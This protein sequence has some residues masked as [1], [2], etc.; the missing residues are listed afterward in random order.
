MKARANRS[1]TAIVEITECV[2]AVV[3]AAHRINLLALNAMLLSRRAGEAAVGFGVVSNELR[4]FSQLLSQQMHKLQE[5]SFESLEN[6]SAALKRGHLQQLLQRAQAQLDGN[7]QGQ[8]AVALAN[9]H[10]QDQAFE[11]RMASQRQRLGGYLEDANQHCLYGDVI[12]RFA[13]IEAA[14]GGAFHRQLAEIAF[15]FTELVAGVLPQM[16]RLKTM[17]SRRAQG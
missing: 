7:E 13:K 8:V 6:V 11:G 2:K 17:T 5:V 1:L 9:Q 4:G 15:D 3:W 12:A 14:Y 16:N 10:R